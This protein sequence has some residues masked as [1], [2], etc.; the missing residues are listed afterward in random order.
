MA[1]IDNE[2]EYVEM[3]R[4]GLQRTLQE[5]TLDKEDIFSALKELEGGDESR[6]K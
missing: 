2:L 5:D 6:K 1:D 3:T 4:A